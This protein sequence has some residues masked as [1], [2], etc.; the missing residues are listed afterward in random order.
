MDKF[1]NE[2]RLPGQIGHLSVII[3]FVAAILSGIAYFI[4]LRTK[5]EIESLRW[6]RLAR[7]LFG[8][9]AIAV[10]SIV[11]NLYYIIHEHRF[12]YHYAWEHSSLQLPTKYLLACFW[13]GQEG[14]FLLWMFWNMVLGTILIFT[15]KKWETTVLAVFMLVQCFLAS[16]V[17][18]VYIGDYKIGSTPF[19]LLRDYMVDAQ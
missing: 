17:S 3:T 1:E 10:I 15:S 5:D 9:H 19:I 11:V 4:S 8:V 14:S 16:H 7:I 18:G 13:E 12:E 6:K 2:L